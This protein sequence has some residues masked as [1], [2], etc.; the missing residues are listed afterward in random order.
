MYANHCINNICS[1]LI[2]LRL[3]RVVKIIETAIL[4]VSYAHEDE[5]EELRASYAELEVKY[6]QEQEKNQQLLE[7]QS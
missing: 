7:Q 5:L 6:K 2:I 1:L 4:S 3:W